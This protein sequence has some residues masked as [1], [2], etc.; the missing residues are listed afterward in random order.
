MKPLGYLFLAA[1]L[2][3]VVLTPA[4][5]QA[6]EGRH[7]RSDR[8]Q[9]VRPVAPP[10]DRFAPRH[11]HSPRFGDHRKHHRK[12]YRRH[13]HRHHHGH[14]K[15]HKRAERPFWRHFRDRARYY[16]PPPYW[17]YRTGGDRY[18]RDFGSVDFNINYRIFF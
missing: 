13:L 6:D 14:W 2:G 16:A 7:H 17:G 9:L 1:A 15:R 11:V 12:H 5:A 3:T 18:D 8:G 4:I 10:S